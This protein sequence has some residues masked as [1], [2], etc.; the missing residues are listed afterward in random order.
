MT[1]QDKKNRKGSMEERRKGRGTETSIEDTERVRGRR[2]IKRKVEQ[3]KQDN[4]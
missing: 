1:Q 3:S 2:E 4:S